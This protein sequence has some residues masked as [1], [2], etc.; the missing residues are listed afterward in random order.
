ML[1]SCPNAAQLRGHIPL[2][3]WMGLD[4]NTA[5][6]PVCPAAPADRRRA[7]PGGCFPGVSATG[8]AAAGITPPAA[9]PPDHSS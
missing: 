2:P 8:Y 6:Q 9:P 4:A 1:T 3:G 5:I 7:L